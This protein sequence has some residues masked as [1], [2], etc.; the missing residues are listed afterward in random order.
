MG[1]A[2]PSS[3]YLRRRRAGG[4]R[5]ARRPAARRG[6][7]RRGRLKAPGGGGGPAEHGGRRGS[8]LLAQRRDSPPRARHAPRRH[9]T[10]GLRERGET[11]GSAAPP[12]RPLGSVAKLRSPRGGA[13]AAGHGD[14]RGLR[15]RGPGLSPPRRPAQAGEEPGAPGRAP[16]P[17]PAGGEP[18]AGGRRSG[19]RRGAARRAARPPAAAGRRPPWRAPRGRPDSWSRGKARP[20]RQ[21]HGAGSHFVRRGSPRA[22]EGPPS[23]CGLNG[24]PQSP[25]TGHHLRA[26]VRSPGRLSPTAPLEEAPQ[27]SGEALGAGPA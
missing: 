18:R 26:P 21:R 12:A 5:A 25:P 20:R 11:P 17:A 8:Q 9:P 27:L 23:P 3:A 4:E 1:A 14:G 13:S 10:R 24:R 19:E 2:A 7:A 15:L 6:A 22:T 16:A